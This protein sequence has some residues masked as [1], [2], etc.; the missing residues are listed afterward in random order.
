MQNN[1]INLE[2]SLAQSKKRSRRYWF[3]DGIVE[4]FTGLLFFFVGLMFLLINKFVP[5]QTVY[6]FGLIVFIV[7]GI[8]AM[9]WGIKTLK[10]RLIYPR[11][12]YITLSDN[13]GTQPLST[14]IIAICTIVA[15]LA[16]LSTSMDRLLTALMPAYPGLLVT[17]IFSYRL[18][19]FHP[20]RHTFLAIFSALLSIGIIVSAISTKEVGFGIYFSAIGIAQIISGIVGLTYYLQHTQP[21]SETTQ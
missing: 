9:R 18:L 5:E 6:Y 17:L 20:P 21:A 4:I 15:L 12:G 3:E 7:L 16:F 2:A 11:T 13:C 10:E 8:L 14:L 1:P 19:D